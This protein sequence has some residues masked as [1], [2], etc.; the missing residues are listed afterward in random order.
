MKRQLEGA[1][2]QLPMEKVFIGM[3][4]CGTTVVTFEEE[5]IWWD[6]EQ[7]A[8]QR[9]LEATQGPSSAT[10]TRRVELRTAELTCF[11][12]D[13]ANGASIARA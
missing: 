5:V 11:I 6:E 7:T 9:T 2:L 10:V 8:A 4:A 1:S 12:L 13:K 3:H